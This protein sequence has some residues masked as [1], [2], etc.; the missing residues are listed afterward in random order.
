MVA[1]HYIYMTHGDI[2]MPDL[3]AHGLSDRFDDFSRRF[4]LEILDW[5]NVNSFQRRRI[6]RSFVIHRQYVAAIPTKYEGQHV[7]C[8]ELTEF[9]DGQLDFPER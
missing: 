6:I 7:D 8:T 3:R 4:V 5:S 1:T 9:L 2:P